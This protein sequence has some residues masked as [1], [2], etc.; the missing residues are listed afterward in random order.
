MHRSTRIAAGTL[1]VLAL[2]ACADSTTAPADASALKP[3][4][5]NGFPDNGRGNTL[6]KMN[7][8]AHPSTPT[9]D[10]LNDQGKRIPLQIAIQPNY[11]PR[12]QPVGV[13]VGAT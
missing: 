10:M 12:A 13:S 2:A 11:E 6:Y 4:L 8:I 3:Q 1:A 9:A 5:T 7:L